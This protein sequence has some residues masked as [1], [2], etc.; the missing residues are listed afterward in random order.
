MK[1]LLLEGKPVAEAWHSDLLAAS[2]KFTRTQGRRP[3][4]AV[5]AVGEDPASLIYIGRKREKAKDL[6]IFFEEHSLE[7]FCA[8]KTLKEK[9]ERLNENP[10]IDGIILQLPIPPSLEVAPLLALIAP[11]KD[12][13][14]LHPLNRGML[15]SQSQEGFVPCTPLGCLYLLKAYGFSLSGKEVVVVG[16]SLL[17]GRPLAALCLRENATVTIAHSQTKDLPLITQRA[18]FLFVALGQPD[19]IR[20]FHVKKGAVVLDI[21]INRDEEN[22]LTGDVNFQEVVAV[23]SALS[24][25]PGG[26]GPLTVMGL[27]HNTLKAAFDQCALPFCL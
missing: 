23:A 25:V 21:G 3:G 7:G 1:P 9:I 13:D 5:I 8:F 17:V 18:D 15:Y 6:G 27:M 12:V 19:F 11:T 10:L 22:I 20:S 16:R 4:L 14:G 26:V 2:Q 24:P